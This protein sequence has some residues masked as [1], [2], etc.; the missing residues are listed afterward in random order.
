[1]SAMCKRR[2]DTAIPS[3]NDANEMSLDISTMSLSS[4]NGN[5]ENLDFGSSSNPTIILGIQSAIT[6]KQRLVAFHRLRKILQKSVSS[7]KDGNTSITSSSTLI[8]EYNSQC[9]CSQAKTSTAVL[10]LEQFIIKDGGFTAIVM[11][12]HHLVHSHGTTIAE[13][14][15][16]CSC[17]SLI[18]RSCW[19][20]R[21][22]DNLQLHIL[23]YHGPDL[24]ILLSN[25][26][27]LV[28]SQKK[29]RSHQNHTI[30]G[31]HMID[32]ILLN[33]MKIFN[34]ISSSYVGTNYIIKCRFATDT[35]V[36]ILANDDDNHEDNITIEVLGCFKNITYYQEEYRIQLIQ[37]SSGFIKNLGLLLTN[38]STMSMNSRQRLSAVI[39]NLSISIECRAI[40]VAHPTVIDTLIQLLNCEQPQTTIN[41]DDDTLNSM[42]RNVV[43]TFVSLAMDHDSALILIF[44]GDGILLQVLQRHL[45][46]S[47]DVFLRKKSACILRLLAHEM[48]APL[49]VH[50]AN[51]MHSLSDAALRDE[52]S[53]VRKE[54]AEAFAR[55]AAF[56]Q[57]VEQQPEYYDSVLDAL[58][59]LVTRRSRLKVVAIDSL[60]RALRDQSSHESNQIPMADRSVLL[61]A[62]S[63][64]AMSKEYETSTASRD[65]TFALMNLSSHDDNLEKLAKKPLLLDAL[66]SIASSYRMNP[67]DS[68]GDAKTYALTTLVNL[69]RNNTCRKTMIRHGCLLQ[70]LIQEIKYIPMEQKDLKDRLKHASLLLASDL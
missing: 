45:K 60:A 55:C 68:I 52:S 38:K 7:E 26:V 53:D 56:V 21:N 15:V 50:D 13:L 47:S 48:S 16:L 51:L 31:D 66:V 37:S 3:S 22:K 19:R 42:K 41:G 67:D 2:R 63:E 54:A 28:T 62:L 20:R 36:W 58:T 70:T 11:Q 39:R 30:D 9:S 69:T 25:T 24:L 23:Q 33:V 49:L 32:S 5:K 59:V 57:V 43:N 8:E 29:Q 40:L 1:M 6:T 64:M 34:I 46:E 4:T 10:H 17:L 44:Y 65:A 61:D 27:P 14:D 12:L 18:F 35:M